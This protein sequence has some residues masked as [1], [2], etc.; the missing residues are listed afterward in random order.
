[1]V[2]ATSA[3]LEADDVMFSLAKQEEDE[4]GRALVFTGDRDLYA[5]VSDAVAVVEV[6]KGGEVLELGVAEVRERDGV[7]RS[8]VG[9]CSARSGRAGNGGPLQ[10]PADARRRSV[11]AHA[12][13]TYGVNLTVMTSPSATA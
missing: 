3:E 13:E 5:A 8:Q 11:S 6:R 12:V 7:E 1:W 10:A 9:D 2:V 4:R